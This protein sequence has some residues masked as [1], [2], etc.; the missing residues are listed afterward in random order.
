MFD[1]MVIGG[2][3]AGATAALRARELGAHVALVERGRFGGTCT[4]DGCVPTRVLAKAARLVRDAEQFEDYALTGARPQVDFPGLL[5][6]T[7]EIVDK[8]HAKKQ[9][10]EHLDRAGI[11][12]VEGEARFLDEHTVAV[13]DGAQIQAEK[14]VICAGGHAR[15]LPFPGGDL[16]LTHSDVWSMRSL[17]RSVA[18]VGAAATGCQL[19]SVFAAFGTHVTLLEMVPRVLPGE[20]ELVSDVVGEALRRSGI[21]IMVGI[22]GVDRI[23]QA[24]RGLRLHYNKQDEQHTVEAEAVIVA[25]G[26]P[27]NVDALNLPAAN[28]RAERSYIVVDD[29]LRTSVPHIFA[30]G[31][32]TGRMMLVQSASHEAR[33]AVENALGLAPSA[34]THTIVPHGGFTDPEYGSVGLTEA[35]ARKTH[36]CVVAVVPYADLDRAVVDGRDEGFCKLI[37]DRADGEILGAHVVGEQAVEVVQ[38]VAA[39]MVAGSRVEQ[40]AQIELA[41]PTFTAIVGLAAR[42]LVRE[43]GIVPVVPEWRGIVGTR[44]VEWER[45]ER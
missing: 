32:I 17:P 15:R 33:V 27:G 21:E 4:N 16:A 3:P 44:P 26:W 25:V 2:G 22:E 13:S 34:F 8:V 1:L 29:F 18:I 41:Y 28:I 23:E 36:D 30:A 11:T 14:F 19:A 42:Q 10:R 45:S 12:V 35:N 5:R 7:Q 38:L 40:L 39:A 6:R 31:D 24:D 20:D 43:M 9:L 37:V